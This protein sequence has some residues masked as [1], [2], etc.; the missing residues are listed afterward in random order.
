MSQNNQ[1]PVRVVVT[2][3]GAVT[4]Q[5]GSATALWEGVKAGRVAIRAVQRIPMEGYRTQIGGEIREE[6]V[7]E[8]DYDRPPDHR[9]RVIDFTLKAAEEAIA[10]DAVLTGGVDALSDILFSGFN[11]LE[12]LSPE[13]AAPYS[14]TR[15]G[16]SLGEGSGM[17]VLMRE[18]VARE[19]GAPVLAELAGYG[20]SADGYHPTAP[21]PDGRCDAR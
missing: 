6:I 2:G 15:T 20:L 16:L 1:Q 12:S 7:P 9:E 21:H 4:S 19:L 13:P 3:V 18:S 17:V 11:S 10:A 14:R 8:H 5:G